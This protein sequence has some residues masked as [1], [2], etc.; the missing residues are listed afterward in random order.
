MARQPASYRR[1]GPDSRPFYLRWLTRAE[2][3]V[4]RRLRGSP[5]VWSAGWSMV[6]IAMGLTHARKRIGMHPA[7]TLPVACCVPLGLA[8]AV[9]PSRTRYVAVAGGYMWLFKTSW[10]LPYDDPAWLRKRLLVDAPI[11]LDSMLG[12]GVPP[13][14]RLQRALR[15]EPGRASLLDIAVTAV[16]AS[17]FV[18]HAVLGYLLVRHDQ[19][20]PRAGGRLAASNH[21][22]TPFYW[23]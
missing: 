4:L 23:V 14:L 8:I 22:T 9:P 19:Y 15:R 2:R 6:A 5:A 12:L 20:V 17:W 1:R 18:P 21:L 13:G 16:Y 11:R 7:I 3:A 10:E